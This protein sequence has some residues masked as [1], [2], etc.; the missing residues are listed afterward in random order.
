MVAV[1]AFSQTPGGV[2][3]PT[4]ASP[5]TRVESTRDSRI[6]R[7]LRALY[8]QFTDRPARLIIARAPSSSLAQS[9]SV[10][11]S[12]RTLRIDC[13]VAR[14]DRVKTTIS[15]FPETSLSVSKRPM[16]PL[17]PATTMRFV[18]F[19]FSSKTDFPESPSLRAVG[20]LLLAE[21]LRFKQLGPNPTTS[22]YSG[23]ASRLTSLI[24]PHR[25]R[26]I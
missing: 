4:I 17:P 24:V 20:S 16:K 9:P 13:A 11:P 14:G 21:F 12:H 26:R 22:T 15:L 2:L 3:Q 8:R 19:R 1:L 6:S 23:S 5:S 25:L 7:R 18:I 10:R